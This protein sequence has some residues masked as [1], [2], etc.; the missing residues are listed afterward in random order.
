MMKV[1]EK[2]DDDRFDLAIQ[3]LISAEGEAV[4]LDPAAGPYTRPLFS[5]T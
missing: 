3:K 2:L 4:E 5:T 1:T